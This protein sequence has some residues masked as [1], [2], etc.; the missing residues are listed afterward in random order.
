MRQKK[1]VRKL[2]TRT[3]PGSAGGLGSAAINRV[4]NP[5][6]S[7]G[8][9]IQTAVHTHKIHWRLLTLCCTLTAVIPCSIDAKAASPNLSYVS[10]PGVQRG[11]EHVLTVSGARLADVEEALLYQKGVTV[12]KVEPVDAANAKVTVEVAPDCRLGEQ[13]IQLRTRSG[14]SDY[15]SFFVGALPS[16]DEKEPN[17]SFDEPQPIELNHTVAGIL[18]NEDADYYRIHA[19]KGQ[20]I[21]VEVEAIRLGQAY[22]DPFLAI[23]DKD[24]FE[25]ASVDDTVLAKQDCFLSVVIPEDGEYTVL[26]RET[27]YRGADNCRYRVHIGNFPRP[28]VAYPAGGKRGEQV[29][30][31][32]LGDGSGSIERDIVVPADP[33]ALHEQVVQDDHGV[34]PSAVP[35]RHFSDGNVMEMEP[36]DAFEASTA[37]EL[38]LA[39][40]GRLEKAADVDFFKLVAKKGQVWEVECY[41]RR[42]GSP[43]DPVVTIYNAAKAGVVGADDARGQDS[44][45]RFAVP[46][47]GEYY[48]RVSDHLGQGGE[49]YVYRVEMT[50]VAP[51]LKLGIPRIDRYSQT[52]Q[53]IVVPRGNRYGTLI[54]ATRADFGGP[55]E[56]SSQGVIPGVTMKAQPMHPSMTLMPVVFEAAADAPIDGD[57]VDLR[58]KLA[59]PNQPNVA[60]EGG[61]ENNADFV[62]GEPNNAVYISG[63]ADKVPIVVAKEV[64]F[65]LEI[66]QPKVPLVRSGTM[67]LKVV[68]HRDQGFDAPIYVQFPFVPPGVGAAGAINIDKGQTEGLYP[69]NANGDAAIGKWPMIAIGAAEIDGQAWVSS[70]LADLDIADRYVS[71]EVKRAACDQGQVA[72]VPCVITHNTPFEGNAKAELLGLP[73]GATADPLE[74]K[75][76]TA[77]LIFQVK[78]TD[79]TPVGSH[80]SLFCQVSITQNGEPIVGSVGASELQ[81]NAPPAAAPTPPPEAAKPAEPAAA[82]PKPLS[83]LEQLRAKVLSEAEKK[84]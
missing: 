31:Q 16:V 60:I 69:L 33:K 61:F 29:K 18:Q 49:T 82:P 17:S 23:L 2:S 67:N 36:N 28:T 30:V 35:F 13:L 64:P 4:P 84:P 62:L 38:P 19:T 73:P 43:V 42:I 68:V 40:N 15:R 66:V 58:G 34:T 48:V 39:L 5:R 80:K 63:I 21:S 59:D 75:H 83:R 55:I 10:P 12:K 44:Y 54:M 71:F 74:F 26:V 9:S 41:A 20:R 14:V 70:Q 45:M 1:G 78:T 50:P 24:R 81:V 32:F 65:K 76:D 77:E 57:L 8:L 51:S 72:Q 22:F 47:D 46:E 52:R 37:A 7:R 53:T 27:S 3:A 11:H 25:L 6:Q 56:L 79:G